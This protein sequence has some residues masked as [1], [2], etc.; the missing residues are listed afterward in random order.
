VAEIALAECSGD[1]ADVAVE[2]DTVGAVL[3]I[4]SAAEAGAAVLAAVADV[5]REDRVYQIEVGAV[6]SPAGS[7]L[8][9]AGMVGILGDV[10]DTPVEAGILVGP[11]VGLLALRIVPTASIETVARDHCSQ[12]PI[13]WC[14]LLGPT[15]LEAVNECGVSKGL[16]MN[17]S[18]CPTVR[19]RIRT[20]T[21]TGDRLGGFFGA[22]HNGS[23]GLYD[24]FLCPVGNAKQSLPRLS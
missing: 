18:E 16:R 3:P 2:E 13:R 12:I 14:S 8:P 23:P 17:K 19:I 11:A 5:D 22:F 7:V 1:T 15:N 6:R 4:D 9:A 10:T 24:C 21:S 20:C